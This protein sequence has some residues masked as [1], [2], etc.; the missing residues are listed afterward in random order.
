MRMPVA[1]L[2]IVCAI[3]GFPSAT[4][5]PAQLPPQDRSAGTVVGTVADKA[6]N[7][8]IGRAF[9]YI[10]GDRWHGDL[11]PAVDADGHFKAN[12][13]PGLY[14]IFVASGGFLPTCAVLSVES[15]KQTTYDVR[16]GPDNEHLQQ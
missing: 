1:R 3:L 11:Q 8:P 7:A 5:L 12:L 14:D 2:I 9:V 16:L 15:G 6:E 4:K 13:A 10:H